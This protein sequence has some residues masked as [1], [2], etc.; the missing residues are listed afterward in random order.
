M[1]IILQI[2]MNAEYIDRKRNVFPTLKKKTIISSVP[3]VSNVQSKPNRTNY[4]LYA[5]AIKT[6]SLTP[7]D[8]TRQNNSQIQNARIAN[9]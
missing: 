9:K 7:R 5:Q 8:F 4:S 2:T 6:P 3:L 1:E